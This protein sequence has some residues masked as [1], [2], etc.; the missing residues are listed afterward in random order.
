MSEAI[1]SCIHEAAVA[2]VAQPK[3]TTKTDLHTNDNHGVSDNQELAKQFVAAI[4]G[5]DSVET[6]WDTF[7]L[8]KRGKL[9]KGDWKRVIN[10]TLGIKCSN[11]ERRQLRNQ[12][13]V[14]KTK[15]ITFEALVDYLDGVKSGE[16]ST[17]KRRG[18]KAEGKVIIVAV[19]PMDVPSLPDNF[20]PRVNV[21]TELK[22]KLLDLKSKSCVTAQGM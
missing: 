19:L 14:H 21:E 5:F 16:G 17:K 2:P 8:N 22:E 7:D 12:I 1:I 3:F 18:K 10:V 4:S 13:D 6:A 20:R 11:E 9:T 15:T